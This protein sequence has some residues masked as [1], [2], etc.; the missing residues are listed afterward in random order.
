MNAVQGEHE[1]ELVNGDMDHMRLNATTIVVQGEHDDDLVKC[2]VRDKWITFQEAGQ[3]M[4]KS[5]SAVR[6]WV[7]RRK[8]KG[9]SVQMKK[10]RGKHGDIWYIH[11]SELNAFTERDEASVQGERRVSVNTEHLNLVSLEY[12]D[13][14][15]K[16]WERERD[17]LRS[18]LMMYRYKF[19]EAEKRLKLLPAP[20][21]VV[22][23]KIGDLEKEGQ[24]KSEALEKTERLL[25]QTRE[26]KEKYKASLI[27]L[28]KKLREEA[29]ATETYKI[30]CERAM[31]EARKPWWKKL[32][33]K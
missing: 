33:S 11:S 30:E 5:S 21:E 6:M 20:A 28:R 17:D 16:L 24:Q 10:E 19:E 1:D 14:Q 23:S 25:A 31:E 32:F 27:E 4:K 2:H 7:R 22:V 26:V 18:G 12:H 9:E 3:L 13:E 29:H 8:S 15:R